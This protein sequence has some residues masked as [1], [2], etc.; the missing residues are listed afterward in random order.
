MKNEKFP[1]LGILKESKLVK[2][3]SQELKKTVTK[4]IRVMEVCGTHTMSIFQY[5]LRFL[6]P[7]GLQMISGPGCPVCVTSQADMDAMIELS[8][9]KDVRLVTFGDMLRVPGSKISL[10]EAQ[11]N[12]A[13]VHMV[14][15]P[16]D[17]IDIAL[18]YPEDEVVFAGI[19][20][21]TTAPGIA[22]TV[23]AAKEKRI[24]NFAVYSTIKLIPPALISLF[25]SGDVYVDGLLCPGH[26][27]S[28]IGAKRYLPIKDFFGIPCVVTGFEPADILLGL[29][30]L[31]KQIQTGQI[32]VYNAYSRAVSWDGN[33]KALDVMYRVFDKKDAHWR[34]LGLIEKSGLGLKSEF[35]DFCAKVRFSISIDEK[36]SEESKGCRCGDILKGLISPPECPLFRKSCSPLRPFGPCMVSN[37][38]TCHA[39]YRYGS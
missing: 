25:S 5:G 12:G 22:A 3:L 10:K 34:G 32:D 28:I 39:Y 21:E 6:F 20:F 8:Q 11:A 27:S 38:G 9:K 19:G 36:V 35:K 24:S 23:L 30:E 1:H 14:Y 16:M 37:E 31:T 4:P 7:E 26:V 2:G 33:K 15:S 29:L 13:K 17:S 18:K